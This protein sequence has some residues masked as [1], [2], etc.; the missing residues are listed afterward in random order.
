[1]YSSLTKIAPERIEAASFAIIAQEFA[2]RTGLRIDDIDPEEFAVIQR[3]IHAS[4]DFSF[5]HNLLFHPQAIAT[6]K[7][8]LRNGRNVLTDVN[9]AAAGVSAA[10]LE[11]LGGRVLCRLSDPEIMTRAKDQGRTRS[12]CAITVGLEENNVGIVAIGNAPTALVAA[13]KE[14]AKMAPEERPLV[15]G[16]PVGFVNAAESKEILRWQEYPFITA[17]GRKGGS[18]IAAAIVNALLRLV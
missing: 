14:V 4:G 12:E 7:R 18:P 9:I 16:V 6:A 15:V 10:L 2:E 11:S 13:M 3:V 5:A 1:M 17:L 8:H